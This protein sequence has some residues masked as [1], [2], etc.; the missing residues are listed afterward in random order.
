MK[1]TPSVDVRHLFASA[2]AIAIAVSLCG[3]PASE[4]KKP[5]S[6][7]PV[8]EQPE[9]P[10]APAASETV[11]PAEKTPPPAPAEVEEPAADVETSQPKEPKEP[12]VIMRGQRDLGPPLVD[13]PEQLVP[14]AKDQPVWLDRPNGQ[15]IL[16][17][18]VCEPAYLLE[19]FATYA[20]RSYESV[21]A[22]NA[23]PSI[24]HTGLVAVGAEPGHPARFDQQFT[25]PTGTEIAIEVRWKDAEGKVQ[26]A[27]AQHWVRN[28]KTGKALDVNWVFAG[29]GFYTDETT[30]KRYYQADSGE[31]ICVLSLPNAMLDLPIRS[32]GGIEERTFEAFKEHLPPAGTP[33]TILLKPIL[34]KKPE[35]K[36]AGETQTQK[37]LPEVDQKIAEAEKK[38][39]EAA[40]NWLALI[41]SDQYTRGWETAA[42]QLSVSTPR[43]EFIQTLNETRK[44]FGKVQSRKLVANTYTRSIPNGPDGQYVIIEFTTSFANKPEVSEVVTMALNG[45]DKWRVL[46]YH[47]R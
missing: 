19:F 6:S 28:T 7:K 32:L 41:D 9:Q 10:V 21:L 20:N 39:L 37:S 26:S 24:V 13:N 23:T 8:V 3:C 45:D 22:V 11:E 35:A 31:L 1:I 4:E 34:D 46:G 15:V 30:G 17:G 29:S 5:Q 25:P 2:I 43:R 18:E 44:P 38:A 36:P 16:L 42:K 12:S 14:L 40:E 27:P 47:F 33:T